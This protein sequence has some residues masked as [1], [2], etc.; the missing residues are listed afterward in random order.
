RF[1]TD[2]YHLHRTLE[3]KI[4]LNQ[5][6]RKYILAI[7]EAKVKDNDKFIEANKANPRI[8]W[9]VI[10]SNRSIQSS[11]CNSKTAITPNEFNSF[12]STI[13]SE[14][15]SKLPAP[16]FDPIHIMKV[17]NRGGKN[18][19]LFTNVSQIDVRN[20]INSLKNSHF[21]DIFGISIG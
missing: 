11:N 1:I 8:L 6:K 20:A 14:I 2:A 18:I 4:L 7:R 15:K 10:N 12:F 19:F 16:N 17:N 3:L 13:A 21:K 5:F 9:K